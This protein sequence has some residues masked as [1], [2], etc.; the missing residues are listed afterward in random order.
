MTVVPRGLR[1]RLLV[2]NLIVA[3]AAV[4][5]VL[6]GVSLV[7]PG[8]FQEAM[9]HQPGD[10]AGRQ[11]DALT[12]A[13]FH[14]AVRTALL[15]AAITALAAAVVVSLALSSR[16][17]NPV[18]RLVQAARRVAAGHYAE[19]VPVEGEG[20]I[21]ELAGAF[22]SMS[23]S[24]EGT[25]RRRLQLVGDVAHELRTPLTTLDG[26]L[27]GLQD[28]VIEPTEQ[29]WDLLRRETDRLMRLVGDLAELWRAEARQLPLQLAPV[30]IEPVVADLLDRFSPGIAERGLR[31]RAAIPPGTIV[32]ADRDRLIQIVG[33]YLSNAVRHAPPGSV[34]RLSAGRE[35]PNVHLSVTDDGP[36]L[37]P[38]QRDQVFER[39]YRLDAARSRGDGGAGIGLSIVRALAEAMD[40]RAWAESPGP[41]LGSTFLV[42]L[43]AASPT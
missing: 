1:G 30:D 21:G 20:E 9:G 13:A 14:E 3:A 27:E 33:N 36:G 39:F 7:G 23:A 26:Y 10:P 4:G 6:V 38:E 41:G 2:A 12:L 17:A 18:S 40:G 16:I 37:T 5:T 35:G 42:S 8:Y 29:T 11:M 28:G 22:N 24:L 32:R 31:V 25:E 34:I 19:R 43:P 15:A